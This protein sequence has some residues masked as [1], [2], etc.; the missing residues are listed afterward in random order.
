M[1]NKSHRCS[2]LLIVLC[3]GMGYMLTSCC[4]ILVDGPPPFS[5]YT[6]YPDTSLHTGLSAADVDTVHITRI[7]IWQDS[8]YPHAWKRA[9][10]TVLF[11]HSGTTGYFFTGGDTT[12]V[13]L[14]FY[15]SNVSETDTVWVNTRHLKWT[16]V[17]RPDLY[18]YEDGCSGK[19]LLARRIQINGVECN[20]LQ[21]V[22]TIFGFDIKNQ[23]IWLKK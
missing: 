22:Q 23:Q 16:F 20:L 18:K 11:R 12:A 6:L 7:R 17:S 2:L 5:Y 8:L 3:A 9:H 1:I 4:K 21:P 10:D 15:L 19:K 13:P 14:N